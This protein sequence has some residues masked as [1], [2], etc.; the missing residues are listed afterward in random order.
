MGI[1]AR[2]LAGVLALVLMTSVS[3]G[4]PAAQ[5]EDSWLAIVSAETTPVYCGRNVAFYT[6][7]TLSKDDAVVVRRVQQIVP[8]SEW[9]TVE[10]AGRFDGLVMT[11]DVQVNEA[12][13]AVTV[14]TARIYYIK[15]GSTKVVADSWRGFDIGDGV[16]LGRV[17]E[18]LASADGGEFLR[19][20]LPAGSVA[21][22]PATA[23]REATEAERAA[24]EAAQAAGAVEEVVEEESVEEVTE[25]EVEEPVVEE[26]TVEESAPEVV[27]EEV[28]TEETV[29]GMG[30]DVE[31]AG[32][33]QAETPVETA[34]ETDESNESELTPE[35]ALPVLS[36][37]EA[38]YEAMKA[39][40]LL[41]A[42][43]GPLMDEYV[44]LRD[45]ESASSVDRRIAEIRVEMLEVRLEAQA[46][47]GRIEAALA[48][49]RGEAT[50]AERVA[51]LGPVREVSARG[52][53]ARSAVYD[54][55]GLPLLYRLHE[56]NTGRTI[57]YLEPMRGSDLGSWVGKEVVAS[58]TVNREAGLSVTVV[59]PQQI[60]AAGP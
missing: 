39:V 27:E 33:A 20:A 51:R 9:A 4:Q 7:G 3:V 53:V 2:T 19:V 10:V 26:E 29:E 32:D 16:R 14:G 50:E 1:A 28:V 24:W 13:E 56:P 46:S 36:D 45:A 54:G 43:I 42:E 17:K 59:Q 22:V 15:A 31:P 5:G 34:E 55:E 35:R 23:L 11:S 60:V 47:R 58:G 52:V 21:Y 18:R 44:R 49:A 48:E 38:A 25:P 12:G 40:P 41:E 6:L 8:S 30:E 57:L 37:L